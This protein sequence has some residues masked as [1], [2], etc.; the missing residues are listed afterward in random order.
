VRRFVAIAAL[1]AAVAGLSAPVAPARTLHFPVTVTVSGSGHV[2]EIGDGG[3]IDC[4]GIC[5]AHSREGT[6][7][8]LHADPDPGNV[9]TGWGG[10]CAGASDTSCGIYINAD[11]SVTAGFGVAPPPPPPPQFTLTV[12]KT[13][14]G[15]GFVGASGI[16]CGTTCAATFTQG[17]GVALVAV[18]DDGST[19]AGWSG[20]GCSGTGQCQVTM[21]ADTAV[22]ATFDHVDRSPPVVSTLHADARRGSTVLLRYRIFDDSGNARVLVLVADGKRR[23]ASMGVPLGKVVYRKIYSVPWKVPATLKPGDKIFCVTG[24]DAAGNVS[25]RSC[26]LRNRQVKRA[27][28][29]VAALA[30]LT[31]ATARPTATRRATSST[32]RTCSCPTRSP[33]RTW[34]RSSRPR[35]RRPPRRACG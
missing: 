31:A 19:F 8:V 6:G 14:T 23:L 3:S 35:S 15:T 25:K 7:I 9:F 17:V 29:L 13:G 22:T 24:T 27:L 30:A 1:A 21:G 18:A 5:V 10:A 33:R 4:P 28:V 16:D 34:P 2:R 11:T 32:S 26:S 12:T 20:G